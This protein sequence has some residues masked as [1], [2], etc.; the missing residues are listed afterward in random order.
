MKINRNKQQEAQEKAR[1]LLASEEQKRAETRLINL[2]HALEQGKGEVLLNNEFMENL[3]ELI[4][5][6]CQS[7][8]RDRVRVLINRLGECACSKDVKLRERAVMA[9]SLCMDGLQPEEHPDLQKQII[10]IFLQWLRMETIFLSV[11]SPVCK[12]LQ[13]DGVRLLEEGLWKECDALLDL[14]YT[15]QS[16][17]LHKSNAIRSVV[18]RA[19]DGMAADHILEELTLISL[20]GRGERRTIAEKTLLHLGRKAATHLLDSLISSQ[21]KEDRLRLLVLIPATGHVSASVLKEYLQ[22]A[23]PWYAIRNIILMIAALDDKEL[24]SLVMPFLEHEDVRVQQQALDCIFE[25]GEEN[26]GRYLLAALHDVNDELKPTLVEYLGKTAEPGAM[27][28]FLDL[29]AQRDEIS[30]HARD[31]LLQTLAVQVRLSDSVRAVNLLNTLI[32]ERSKDHDP[33]SD[34]VARVAL[35]SLQI[36]QHRFADE[37]L[38]GEPEDVPEGEELPFDETLDSVSFDG[39]PV[40]L[41][42]AKRKIQKINEQ[43]ASLLGEDKVSDASQLLYEKCVEAAMMKDFDV[44]ELLIDRILE[45]DPNAVAQ[46]IRAGERIEEEKSSAVSSSHIS[47]WQDLYDSLTTE[48]FNGLYYALKQEKYSTGSVIVEQGTSSPVLYFINSGQAKISWQRDNDEIFLRRINPG[49]I[50]GR[51]PFFDVSVWTVSLTALGAVGLHVIERETFLE[52][53]EKFPRLESC[54]AEYCQK[55]GSVPELLQMSGEDRRQAVRYPVALIVKHALIE[56]TGE[57]SKRSFKGEITDISSGGLSFYIRVSR[58]ENAR[59][60]LGRNLQSHIP[61]DEGQMVAC[62]GKIVAVRFQQDIERN[63]SVHIQFDEPLEE[64]IVRRIANK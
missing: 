12:Q 11:C 63:Y 14:F 7:S 51:G 55:S 57:V 21:E 45:V 31:E 46:L 52:L 4:S 43:V 39:D 60:L 18:G 3:P 29:L 33:E 50:V 5:A 38:E 54:L 13:T 24:L 36:L 48:E 17:E 22:T 23:L 20:R 34:P 44:A 47:I 19:Q 62:R 32:E 64:N 30:S 58:Q 35:Q 37:E 42:K 41:A 26:S 6:Y 27:D 10:A 8:D 2:E 53:L 16:G 59:L 15:I 9:L 49:E 28:I 1:E 25:R 61:V 56:E 40:T